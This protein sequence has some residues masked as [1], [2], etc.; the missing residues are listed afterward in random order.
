[1]KLFYFH[2]YICHSWYWTNLHFPDAVILSFARSCEKHAGSASPQPQHSSAP[3]PDFQMPAVLVSICALL[4]LDLTLTPV[5]QAMRVTELTASLPTQ[6]EPT[7]LVRE[8]P[9]FLTHWMK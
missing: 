1:M 7:G 4:P 3:W 9:S 8:N 2:S 6:T 5:Q